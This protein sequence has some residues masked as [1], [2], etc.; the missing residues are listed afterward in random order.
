M[1]RWR[2]IHATV[3]TIT[4]AAL[5][6][7]LTMAHAQP[8]VAVPESQARTAALAAHPGTVL[9]TELDRYSGRVAYEFKIQPQSGGPSVDVHVDA[10]TG[11][12]LGTGEDTEPDADDA[13]GLRG[14]Q[15]PSRRSMAAAAAPAAASGPAAAAMPTFQDE[16]NLASRTLSH[17][18][19]SRYFILRPGFQTVLSDGETQLTITVFNETRDIN[20]ITTRVVEERQ[21]T[22]GL[23]DE[24]AL[25]FYAI[26]ASSGDAFYFGEEVD[27]FEQG[28]LTGHPGAWLATD[29]NRP[30]LIM[31][32]S[33]VIGMR[34]Y[35]EVA[36]GVAMDR[37]EV[38]STSETCTTPAGD[39]GECVVTRETSAIETLEEQKS[40]A[41][42]IGL[43][44]DANLRLVS[45]GYVDPGR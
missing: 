33:P 24:I 41:P 39:F 30:G 25:N 16:F 6:F 45:Y 3:A 32:G 10:T 12:V 40:Y 4:V 28:A 15:G 34:Y 38:L 23:P 26:D 35:Q 21:V 37:A 19:E 44:Q 5:A 18:G 7:G 36:P 27:V 13:P 9:E 17:T 1:N 14:G 2:P 11:A 31:P 42:G 8:Q 43:I 29:G 22:A 20:G